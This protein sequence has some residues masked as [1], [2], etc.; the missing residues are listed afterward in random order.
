MPKK[1]NYKDAPESMQ[2]FVRTLKFLSLNRE[3]SAS[4]R[5]CTV[6]IYPLSFMTYT[7]SE[8][9]KNKDKCD[10]GKVLRHG[11]TVKK[12]HEV[13]RM[14]FLIKETA[15]RSNVG[16]VMDLGAGQGYL[17]RMAA[18]QHGLNVLAVDSSEIQTCGAKKFDKHTLKGLANEMQTCN[19]KIAEIHHVTDTV[20][21][22]NISQILTK[23]SHRQD[24]QW[25]VCGLHACGDLTSLMLRLFLQSDKMASLVNVG[26]CYNFLSEQDGFPMSSHMKS[27]LQFTLSPTARMLACQ[28]PARWI[29]R[30]DETVA[31]LEHH[32]FRALLQVSKRH[33]VIKVVMPIK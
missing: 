1:I 31:S 3:P 8:C 16:S 20:T 26:C 19:N 32:Y 22:Q 33:A 27:N 17:S 29:D 2:E 24:E 21:P 7:N 11:M 28:S 10:V 6:Y 13:E 4:S 18:F 9:F 30:K 25:L 23:W 5:Y 12:V 15:D 14:S